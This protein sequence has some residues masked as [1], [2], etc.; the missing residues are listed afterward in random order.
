MCVHQQSQ[1]VYRNPRYAAKANPCFRQCADEILLEAQTRIVELSKR[2]SCWNS[3]DPKL[4]GSDFLK[5]LNEIRCLY[6]S[7]LNAYTSLASKQR[8]QNVDRTGTVV[9]LAILETDVLRILQSEEN[10]AKHRVKGDEY[11]DIVDDVLNGRCSPI[12][13]RR[14]CS[15]MFSEFDKVSQS[16]LAALLQYSRLQITMIDRPIIVNQPGIWK[17]QFFDSSGIT[18]P[19]E[20][21]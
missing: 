13:L 6:K 14:E 9:G 21:L 8:C 1:F 11:M 7:S 2:P 18:F 16:L 12:V 4:Q 20:S 19:T 5:S 10:K 17:N 15:K 3:A